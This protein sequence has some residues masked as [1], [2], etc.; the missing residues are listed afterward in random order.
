MNL[1]SLV[2]FF[3][4]FLNN[5]SKYHLFSKISFTLFVSVVKLLFILSCNLFLRRCHCMLEHAR[6]SQADELI[7]YSYVT[8]ISFSLFKLQVYGFYCWFHVR[9]IYIVYYGACHITRQ[10]ILSRSVQWK[11]QYLSANDTVGWKGLHFKLSI[12]IAMLSVSYLFN[13]FLLAFLLT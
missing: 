12:C 11:L 9:V 3:L 2:E 4:H 10:G 13:K 7:D 6:S 1:K 8:S 5:N